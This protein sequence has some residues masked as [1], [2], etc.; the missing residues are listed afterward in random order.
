MASTSNETRVLRLG[1]VADGEE[2]TNS[3]TRYLAAPKGWLNVRGLFNA[4]HRQMAGLLGR[5]HRPGVMVF[6]LGIHE[7]Q[8]CL[9]LAATDELRSATVG[10]H[11]CADLYLPTDA[12]LS[13]RHCLVL[14]RRVGDGVRV[15]V[16]DLSS[17][18]GLQL[19]TCETV[20]AIDADGHFFLRVPGAVIACFPTGVELPWDPDAMPPFANLA[21]RR[22]AAKLEAPQ[23]IWAAEHRACRESTV[24]ACDGPV[25]AEPAE[26]LEDGE[27]PAGILTLDSPT[28]R[29]ELPVGLSA[30]DRGVVLGRYDR[31]AGRRALSHGSVSRVHALIVRRDESVFIADAG[32]TNG[33]W[34]GEEAVRC[35]RL[36]PGLQYHLGEDASL[37][38]EPLD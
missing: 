14:A 10:R 1:W 26:L 20:S 3:G 27:A 19:E 7:I 8:G 4:H 13:L 15:H 11:G 6:V 37:I 9:W 23:A 21:A 12:S 29:E 16:V 25:S 22:I 35:A 2:A 31:C 24:T 32:S 33:I 34:L 28:G 17:T 30:L 18:A 38:W 5:E 36:A